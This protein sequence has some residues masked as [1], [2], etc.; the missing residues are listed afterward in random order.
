VGRKSEID[1]LSSFDSDRAR[2]A[3][4]IVAKTKLPRSSVFRALRMLV[5]AGFLQQ[6]AASGGYVLGRR[7]LQLGLIARQQLS[8]EDQVAG[9]LLALA[10]R[11]QETVTFSLVDVPWRLCVY[12]L[13]APSDLRS[14]AQ[15]GARYGLHLGAASSAILANLPPEVAAETLRFHHVP[16]REAASRQA[17]LEDI[18]AK[19]VAIAFGQ[20]VVG[21][22]GVAAPIMLGPTVLGSVAVAGPSERLAPRLD[23][24]VADVA[25]VGA[26]LSERLNARPPLR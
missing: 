3:S 6:P 26:D 24:I 11:T 23:A 16:R 2:S 10:G 9:P 18:R 19:G 21:A 20:R 25:R 14:V 13:D 5:D 12:V 8:P 1:I 15:P 22:T 7:M 17:E 4:E